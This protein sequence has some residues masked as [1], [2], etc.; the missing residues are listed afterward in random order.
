MPVRAGNGHDHTVPARLRMVEQQIVR[1][2]VADAAVLDAMRTVPRHEFVPPESEVSAYDDGPLQI[3][4]GQTISQPYIVALMT[5]LI[6]P[7]PGM[8][9]LEIGSGCGYQSA[10]LAACGCVVFAVEIDPELAA[11]SRERLARL[12]IDAVS[13]RRGDGALGWPEEAPFDACLV[14]A[15]PETPPPALFDQL[16]TGGRLVIPLGA[17]EQTLYVFT[18]TRDGWERRRVLDVRFVPLV[19]LAD[20]D[21]SA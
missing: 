11:G 7:R 19:G 20:D 10:V 14:A 13:V 21:P 2:G 1:R 18:R 9:V 6:G 3:G 16:R 17:D 5:E 4:H 8:R 15:A 12:G